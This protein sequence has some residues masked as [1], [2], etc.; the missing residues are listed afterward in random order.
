MFIS[1]TD[2]VIAS[3]FKIRFPEVTLIRLSFS[4]SV[5]RLSKR[6][7]LI[8]LLMEGLLKSIKISIMLS[9]IRGEKAV[10]GWQIENSNFKNWKF[11]LHFKNFSDFYKQLRRQ[12]FFADWKFNLNS[13][14]QK[15]DQNCTKLLTFYLIFSLL[16]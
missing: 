9:L 1:S 3:P 14:I 15:F 10:W 8:F 2:S 4:F 11:N 6:N 7:F 5:F 12:L 16:K 13:K